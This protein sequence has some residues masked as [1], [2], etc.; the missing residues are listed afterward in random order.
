MIVEGG[1]YLLPDM[2]IIKKYNFLEVKPK[3]DTNEI[4]HSNMTFVPIG[5]DN[6]DDLWLFGISTDSLKSGDQNDA[7]MMVRYKD[8][9]VTIS[10]AEAIKTINEFK[11]FLPWRD[12]QSED[13]N[14]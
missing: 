12:L 3:Y 13:D 5:T 14:V 11:K 9:A 1:G 6:N 7:E 2:T 10:R 8:F 4:I